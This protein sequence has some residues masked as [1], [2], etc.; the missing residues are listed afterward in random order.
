V[1]LAALSEDGTPVELAK[2]FD[3]HSMQ[4][5][6]WKHRLL[7]NAA[8]AFGGV[9]TPAAVDLA[10]PQAKIGQLAL[11]NDFLERALIGAGLLSARRRWVQSTN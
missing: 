3:L 7:E 1:A 2:Q 6:E 4:I 8:N 5:V 9:D 11:E 10:S